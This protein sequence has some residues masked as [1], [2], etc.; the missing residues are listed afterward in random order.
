MYCG[1]A[2]ALGKK[3]LSSPVSDDLNGGVLLTPKHLDWSKV[4]GHE[5]HVFITLLR[6][7]DWVPV[8]GR[9]VQN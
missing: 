7:R 9:R 2:L 4:T 5:G 3:N 8:M 6:S 1:F